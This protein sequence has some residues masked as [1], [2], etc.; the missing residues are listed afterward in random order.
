MSKC[1]KIVVS[2]DLAKAKSDQSLKGHQE[3]Q[4]SREQVQQLKGKGKKDKKRKFGDLGVSQKTHSESSGGGG[5][6]GAKPICT[7]CGREGHDRSICRLKNHPNFN[8]SKERSWVDSEQGKEWAAKGKSTLPV[9]ET[10]SGAPWDVPPLPA[11]KAK[12]GEQEMLNMCYV[13]SVSSGQEYEECVEMFLT[14][15]HTPTH[16]H[17]F[18]RVLP[19]T[20]AQGNFISPRAAGEAI[21]QGAAILNKKRKKICSCFRECRESEGEILLDL[22]FLNELTLLREK[23]NITVQ[24][25]KGIPYDIVIGRKSI[26]HYGLSR[27][28]PSVFEEEEEAQTSKGEEMLLGSSEIADVHSEDMAEFEFPCESEVDPSD[29]AALPSKPVLVKH[30]KELLTEVEGDEEEFLITE[31]KLEGRRNNSNF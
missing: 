22:E 1:K 24:I 14:N 27:K 6:E 13:C 21:A 30:V 4:F 19:D 20:G 5:K 17:T 26:K 16:T 25:L 3:Q 7:G 29:P 8:R 2:A 15:K 12:R 31:V 10:I 11:K 9:Y 28:L 23:I 18:S